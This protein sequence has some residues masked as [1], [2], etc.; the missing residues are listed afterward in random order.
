MGESLVIKRNS[1]NNNENGNNIIQG[2]SLE[3]TISANTFVE[4]ANAAATQADAY[5]DS[6][7]LPLS[8]ITGVIIGSS[9][10]SYKIENDKFIYQK[11]FTTPSG[12]FPAQS[13]LIEENKALCLFLAYNSSTSTYNFQIYTLT[14]DSDFNVSF[15]EPAILHN[16]STSNSDQGWGNCIFAQ[17]TDEQIYLIVSGYVGYS[18]SFIEIYAIDASGTQPS[19]LNT[20]SLKSET[21][22]NSAKN[23]LLTCGGFFVYNNK[24]IIIINDKKNN[25]STSKLCRITASGTMAYLTQTLSS[26]FTLSPYNIGKYNNNDGMILVDTTNSVAY[27]VTS[28]VYRPQQL[29]IPDNVIWIGLFKEQLYCIVQETSGC[30]FYSVTEENSE[31]KLKEKMYYL[32]GNEQSDKYLFLSYLY[33]DKILIGTGGYGSGS[34][35]AVFCGN[36]EH[37]GKEYKIATSVDSIYGLSKGVITKTTEGDIMVLKG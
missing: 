28:S 33:D 29:S 20:T 8:A 14:M 24:G 27:T 11:N 37:Y 17:D 19:I 1:N 21:S 22:Y 13:F 2:Y 26:F 18:E 10:I 30:Y 25:Q 32:Y 3:G 7:I 5:G 34:Y 9:N 12:S 31:I 6:L 36:P 4:K 16:G 23:C 35:N 15:S